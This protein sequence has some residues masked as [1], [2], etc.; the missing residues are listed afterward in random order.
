MSAATRCTA[1]G[2]VLAAVALTLAIAGCAGVPP[3]RIQVDRLE[4]GQV[5]AESWKRQ[6]LLNVVS[7]R[8]GDAPMFLDVS[9]IIN[10]YSMAGKASARLELILALP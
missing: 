3:Q 10:S 5:V 2:R 7:M 4:Y 6:T 1:R 9:S 8:Y